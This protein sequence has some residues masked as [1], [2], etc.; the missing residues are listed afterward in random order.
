MQYYCIKLHKYAQISI[1][2]RDFCINGWQPKTAEFK[3]RG[4][5]R[6]NIAILT[7]KFYL[8]PSHFI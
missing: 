1:F 5:M 3:K 6:K 7:L 2:I 4:T 8:K